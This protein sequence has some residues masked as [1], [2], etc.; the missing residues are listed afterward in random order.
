MR[1]ARNQM[2]VEYRDILGWPGYR[3]GDD[4]SV[5][6]CRNRGG[7]G[8]KSCCR[9]GIEWKPRTLTPDKDGYLHVGLTVDGKVRRFL[10]AHLVLNAFVGPCP[11]GFESCHDNGQTG[12]NRR[13]NLRW[14]T[15]Q[16]NSQDKLR[17][18]TQQMGVKCHNAKLDDDSVRSIKMLLAAGVPKIE[19][20]R[21]K[22][23]SRGCVQGIAKG[24][25][26][27]HVG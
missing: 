11:E 24:T 14:D 2:K 25:L 8:G 16:R 18:G 4:C 17:H 12:D 3:V 21:R 22:G 23:I 5:W 1:S 6:S 15:H 7:R 19:I 10:V 13:D 27:K 9:V 26:W 20:A